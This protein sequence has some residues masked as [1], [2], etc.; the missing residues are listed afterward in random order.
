MTNF[1]AKL[2]QDYKSCRKIMSHSASLRQAAAANVTTS[3]AVRAAL[4]LADPFTAADL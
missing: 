4:A 3:K 1:Q 2:V